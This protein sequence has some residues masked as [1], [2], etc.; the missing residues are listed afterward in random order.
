MRAAV[1]DKVVLHARYVGPRAHERSAVILAVEGPDGRPPYFV[2]WDDGHESR[3]TP[4][5][6]ATIEHYPAV[7]AGA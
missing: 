5:S 7:A 4:G 2:R 1:G 3:I 6:D